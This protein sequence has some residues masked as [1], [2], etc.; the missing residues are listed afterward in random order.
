MA[1]IFNQEALLQV[2][3]FSR[4]EYRSDLESLAQVIQNII[5]I[6][7]GTYPN[8]PELGV[9]IK[10][11]L[12]EIID[13]RTIVTLEENIKDQVYRFIPNDKAVEISVSLLPNQ[14][15]KNTLAILCSVSD[16]YQ[17]PESKQFLILVGQNSNKK[18]ISKIIY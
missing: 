3:V 17:N 9:G 10:N 8:Q 12:F 18:V 2:D 6:E 11:Y 15:G 13:G 4:P 5:I 7:K 16:A 1:T 14:L